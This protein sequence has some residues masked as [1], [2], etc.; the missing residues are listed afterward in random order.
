MQCHAPDLI[1]HVAV[2]DFSPVARAGLIERKV[3]VVYGDISQRDTLLHAGVENAEILI[4]TIPD[5]LLK[6]TSNERLV[7]L[8]R[9]LNPKAKIIA[10]AE[11]LDEAH[12]LMAAGADYVSL[13][14][15][16]EAVDLLAAVR[17]AHEGLIEDKQSTLKE[18]LEGRREVLG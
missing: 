4:C 5:S 11:V 15:L 14:R 6:G 3:R 18:M 2:V 9:G 16:H 12:V 10:T 13:A 7:R 17:A 8:L 1:K